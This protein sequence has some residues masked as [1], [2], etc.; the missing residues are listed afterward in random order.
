MPM[1]N[2]TSRGLP[3]RRSTSMN[4]ASE[5]M[6]SWLA[7]ADQ[8]RAEACL[9]WLRGH[10]AIGLFDGSTHLEDTIRQDSTGYLRLLTEKPSMCKAVERVAESIKEV[11]AAGHSPDD[12]RLVQHVG[13]AQHTST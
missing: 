6:K 2:C 5:R 13:D 11:M 10:L 4:E 1:G 7:G 3:L 12:I 9:N 8:K